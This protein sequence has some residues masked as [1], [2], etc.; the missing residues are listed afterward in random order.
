MNDYLR[1]YPFD[2]P[3]ETWPL[4]DVF[5]EIIEEKEEHF[6]RELGIRLIVGIEHEFHL[7]TPGAFF[8]SLLQFGSEK[9]VATVLAEEPLLGIS[10]NILNESSRA[11]ASDDFFREM[12]EKCLGRISRKLETAA[13]ET[14]RKRAE[15]ERTTMGAIWKKRRTQRDEYIQELALAYMH[16]F[17]ESEGGIADLI[18]Y[19][20]GNKMNGKGWVDLSGIYEVRTEPVL[21]MLNGINTSHRILAGIKCACEKFGLVPVFTGRPVQPHIHVSFIHESGENYA[22]HETAEAQQFMLKGLQGYADVLAVTPYMRSKYLPPELAGNDWVKIFP[23]RSSNVRICEDNIEAR[24]EISHIAQNMAL[25]AAGFSLYTLGQKTFTPSSGQS[26]QKVEMATYLEVSEDYAQTNPY[27]SHLF[28]TLSAC[29]IGNDSHLVPD[30][31]TIHWGIKALCSMFKDHAL[32][33]CG[34]GKEDATKLDTL[35]GWEEAL[36]NLRYQDGRLIASLSTPRKL[37]A[38]LDNVPVQARGLPYL[39]YKKFGNDLVISQIAD[40]R[41]IL[42]AALGEEAGDRVVKF[43]AE[44]DYQQR[45]AQAEAVVSTVLQDIEISDD[46]ESDVLTALYGVVQKSLLEVIRNSPQKGDGDEASIAIGIEELR[47]LT[48]QRFETL[49]RCAKQELRLANDECD[50][51]QI[52]LKFLESEAQKPFYEVSRFNPVVVSIIRDVLNSEDN[53][54]KKTQNGKGLIELMTCGYFS[55][56]SHPEPLIELVRAKDCFKYLFKSLGREYENEM[57]EVND[58]VSDLSDFAAQKVD[59]LIKMHLPESRL[60]IGKNPSQYFELDRP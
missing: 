5:L 7:Y 22:R 13:T 8:Q 28:A 25:M 59:E 19:R 24:M 51:T 44:Q 9:D 38:L 53:L 17:P 46:F 45:M 37:A 54:E 31:G 55:V 35:E 15:T 34:Q 11:N 29:R 43:Y 16:L 39:K 1:E 23:S 14:E 12:E 52:A 41:G 47:N 36:K 20:F 42:S 58:L 40:S 6:R 60:E 10:F 56:I 18:E 33:S 3:P 21:G 2:P 4:N 48:S 26:R 57:G 50:Q 30:V 27:L 32:D 49:A